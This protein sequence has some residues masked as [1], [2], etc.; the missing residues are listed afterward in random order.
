MPWTTGDTAIEPEAIDVLVPAA[1][2]PI[3][4]PARPRG[5]STDH[6]RSLAG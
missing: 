6:R 5:R 2:P 1:E 3:E 4:L